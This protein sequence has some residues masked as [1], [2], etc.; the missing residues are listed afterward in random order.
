MMNDGPVT[1]THKQ[2]SFDQRK[3][4]LTIQKQRDKYRGEI[5]ILSV[6]LWGVK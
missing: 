2:N 5:F 6:M 4:K 3:G 1:I